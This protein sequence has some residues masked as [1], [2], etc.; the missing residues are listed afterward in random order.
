MD[1]NEAKLL[2]KFD[3]IDIDVSAHREPNH[4]R[5]T[6]FFSF[7]RRTA[8]KFINF[9]INGE[10]LDLTD[11]MVII[12]FHFLHADARKIYTSEDDCLS[13]S[14][15]GEGKCSIILPND[16]YEYS[17]EVLVYTFI[18][19]PDGRSHDA[20]VIVTRFEESWIDTDLGE[21]QQFY[22]KRFEDLRA[23]I[24]A[25]AEL[26]D[27][28]VSGLL[29][30]METIETDVA[31]FKDNI[32][33]S[34]T[35]FKDGL[36]EGLDDFKANATAE[37][38]ELKSNTASDL[39]DIKA[40]TSAEMDSLKN[41]TASDL[42]SLKASTGAEIDELRTNTASE[43]EELKE[44]TATAIDDVKVET[45]GKL[46][47]FL[48]EMKDKIT[49]VYD[50]LSAKAVDLANRIQGLKDDA[51]SIQDMIGSGGLV[52]RDVLELHTEDLNNPHEVTIAQIPGLQEALD[53]V[54]DDIELSWANIT[55]RPDLFPPE[56]H[57]H[58]IDAIV[59]LRTE[60]G[61][62]ALLNH[63]H[64]FGSL[65]DV[66]LTFPPSEH[67][68]D[69]EDLDTRPNIP[70]IAPLIVDINRLDGE[71]ALRAT[72][73]W[74]N[75]RLTEIEENLMNNDELKDLMTELF[76]ATK[77]KIGEMAD[78][79][80]TGLTNLQTAIDNLGGGGDGGVPIITW[81]DASMF[82]FTTTVMTQH[83]LVVMVIEG[84][85]TQIIPTTPA[86]IIA[87]IP[88]EFRPTA[89][90]NL[91]IGGGTMHT[92]GMPAERRI[93]REVRTNGEVVLHSPQVRTGTS[94][95]FTWP[96]QN[97]PVNINILHVFSYAR[98]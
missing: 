19:F 21:L 55:G 1:T 74:V 77:D 23:D 64:S 65:L 89:N 12:G 24:L 30:A 45:K 82:G 25:R 66:P 50:D 6:T 58:V 11:A 53:E 97:L 95:N 4:Q 38:E 60:L 43:L 70:N 26:L 29:E 90:N 22:V 93:S 46:A 76:G 16:L 80:N 2:F 36:K 86:T 41:S 94:P 63:V 72:I 59:G 33:A 57:S 44:A 73:Q 56:Q 40:T 98:S 81:Q 75:G 79:I 92:S 10:V 32:Q 17:G 8:K 88:P 83:N 35:E 61:N 69:W 34:V 52:T 37:L 42:A 14:E 27:S 31:N 47:T 49:G 54:P 13:V 71:M 85:S 67:R 9:T 39:A 78:G 62:K 28:D 5:N 20:G 48:E 68:H 87:V 51:D 7:D 15:P 91:A 84:T 96:A 3:E 18:E